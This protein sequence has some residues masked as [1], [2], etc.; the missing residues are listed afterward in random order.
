MASFS[1]GAGNAARILRAPLSLAGALATALVPRSRGD[2]VFGS[3][4]GIADGALALWRESSR[5][6]R[7]WLVTSSD[8]RREA[9][10]LGIR[11]VA[12]DS[13]RGF[14]ITAR[15]RVVVVT[16][17]MGD[18]NRYGVRGAFIVQLWHGIPLKRIGLDAPVT[19]APGRLRRV[20]GIS[21]ALGAAYR[22]T[23]RRIALLPAASHLVRG[24]LES[25]FGLD[26]ARVPVLGEPRVDVLS[27]GSAADRRRGALR[28]LEGAVGGL[29]GARTVLYAP[30]WRDGDPDPAVPTAPDWERILAVLESHDAVL[31]V[32]PH[33]LGG[34][35]YAPSVAPRS[36]D[37][38]GATA[39][40]RMLPSTDVPD[41]TPLLPAV[42]V[43]VTDYSSLVFDI[44]L[45]PAPTLFLAPDVD[46]YARTRGFYGSY[47]DIA[48]GGAARTWTE[49]AARLDSLLG[50]SDEFAR[51]RERSA[52]LSTRVH[53][54]RDGRNAERVHRAIVT[55]VPA[56]GEGRA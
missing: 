13:L 14:W 44:G 30:T 3:A 24:R 33:P 1:F 52:S 18:V 20:P 17:G 49:L 38:A 39:R 55:A 42:D 10:R 31:L 4:A 45:V 46:A 5:S 15:A 35:D 6:G 12:R 47:T 25:A 34:G 37:E 2:W 32:R 53:D 41:V 11:A 19:L 50:D 27:R 29:D 51:E 9:E 7:T 23:Q 21:R 48:D 28:L 54:W 40:V 26:D 56:A 36:G 16:H 8:Q 43:L 22:R